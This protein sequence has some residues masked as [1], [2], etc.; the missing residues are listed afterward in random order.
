MK[1]SGKKIIS[2]LL[3]A[4]LCTAIFLNWKSNAGEGDKAKMLG[5]AAY[6][7]N[8]VKIEE[9]EPFSAKR[10]ERQKAKE[11]ALELIEQ[12]LL[13]DVSDE[14]TKK[15]AQS[16]KIA[17]AESMVKESD[18]ETVL[19][20]KGFENILVTISGEE[21]TVIVD[22]GSLLPAQVVQIQ[23]AVSSLAGILP[24]KIKI[25]LSR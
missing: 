24:E 25:V 11:E 7:N 20:A 4:M 12:V 2:V 5:E 21:A 13:D 1:F 23:E 17:I 18:C 8:D 6:V 22:M 16:K 14:E 19:N 9:Q 15:E 10:I 3:I